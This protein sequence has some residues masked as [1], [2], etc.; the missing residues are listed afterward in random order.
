MVTDNRIRQTE[1]IVKGDSI[2]KSILLNW[3]YSADK[4][5]PIAELGKWIELRTNGKYVLV[6]KEK[7]EEINTLPINKI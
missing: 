6:K 3:L 7:E 2:N 5:L 1:P 4:D